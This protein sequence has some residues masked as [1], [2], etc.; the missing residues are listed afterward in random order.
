[1]DTNTISRVSEPRT[2]GESRAARKERTRQ[3]LLDGALDLV[4]DRNFSSVSLREVARAADI[5]PTAFYRHFGSLEELGVVLVEESM[6]VLRQML[7]DTR[8]AP[9]AKG[10]SGT[11]RTSGSL[12]LL[13]DQVRAHPAQFRFLTRERNG[14]VPEIRRAIDSEM[15]VFVSE[16][17][18][19]LARVPALADWSR[20]DLEAAA[21][22]IVATGAATAVELLDSD[23]PGGHEAQIVE[24]AEK[25]LR[26]VVLGMGAWDPQRS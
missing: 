24:R 2:A 12:H 9:A 16:L 25:Q 11:M 6:R 10:A 14:G 7:R 23:R 21:D 17:V 18:V 1:M 3:A 19:D 4:G 8:R 15:R 5:V 13:A 26:L 20:A 22:L